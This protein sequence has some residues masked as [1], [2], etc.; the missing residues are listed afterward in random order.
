MISR[1]LVDAWRARGAAREASERAHRASVRALLPA[2]TRLLVEDFGAQRVVL[3]GSFAR[4]TADERSD[5]DL[6]VDGIAPER[7]GDAHV[8]VLDA[9]PGLWVD[10]VPA[11]GARAEVLARAELEG[12]TLHAG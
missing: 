6:L 1:E 12:I 11:S 2:V 9:M 3:F 5:V 7:L 8:A 10:L 4:E